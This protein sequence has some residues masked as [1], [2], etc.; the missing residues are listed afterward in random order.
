M[1]MIVFAVII[2]SGHPDGVALGTSKQTHATVPNGGQVVV[3]QKG[4][5][6]VTPPG[7][8]LGV[9][10]SGF[11][12]NTAAAPPPTPNPKTPVPPPT[13]N[14]QFPV[15]SPAIAPFDAA[16]ARQH[17]QAWARHL[18][19]PVQQTNSLG[20]K[21]LFIPP[22][23]F[24]MGAAPE[25]VAPPPEGRRKLP[26][27]KGSSDH[28]R[29]GKP[30]HRVKITKPF[31]LALY[32]VTQAEYEQVMGVNPSAFTEKQ[33]DTPAFQPPLLALEAKYR[34]DDRPKAVGQDTRRHPVETVS[35]DDAQEFC[36]KLSAIPAERV[37]GRVY[38]LPTEAE[39]E[40]ACRAGTTTRWSCGDDETGLGDV[41]WFANYAGL[42]HPVGQKQPN[43]WGLYDMHGNV[44]QW[45][46][47]WFSEDYYQR[48]PPSDPSGP[49]AGNRRVLRGGDYGNNAFNCRSA[50]RLSNG[51]AFRYHNIGFRVAADQ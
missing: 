21:L 50:F 10:D 16:Q 29:E 45:C 3:G 37:A 28:A 4:H 7:K 13:P 6:D 23:E 5:E 41:A 46:A 1:G 43:A 42:T 40:Y 15:P 35:W 8:G 22:G 25:E 51:P 24:D 19:V 33:L 47:D 31:Y 12:P 44:N 32:Q 20:M 27:G 36:R 11:G 48:S 18:G 30:R 38:R 39:W 9:E 14:P 17:Q 49:P 26:P 2:H 34:P